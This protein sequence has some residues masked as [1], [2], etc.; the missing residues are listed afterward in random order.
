MATAAPV[1]A[2]LKGSFLVRATHPTTAPLAAT[3]YRLM[4][5][6]GS[7]LCLSADV[8]T[9]SQLLSLVEEL[10]D[11]IAVLKTHADIIDDF[12]T[13]TI[14]GLIDI[15]R[16]KKFI[17]FEDRKFG[18]IGSRDDSPHH[19]TVVGRIYTLDTGRG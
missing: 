6:K 16:R 13:R 2:A 4:H 8:T 7:N 10:G 9:T 1:P 5:I 11:D 15:G 14:E 12:G 19:L 18:D 17:I 3:L